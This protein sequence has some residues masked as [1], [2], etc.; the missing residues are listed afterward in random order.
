MVEWTKVQAKASLAPARVLEVGVTAVALVTGGTGGIGGA[1]CRRLAA[2][3]FAVVAGDAAVTAS[4]VRA[5]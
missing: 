3:G 2:S 5:I 4:P 1:I